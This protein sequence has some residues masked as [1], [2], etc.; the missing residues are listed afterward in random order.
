MTY[1]EW[2][3]LEPS[4]RKQIQDASDTLTPQLRGLEG[5]LVE[6]VDVE[7]R[8]PRRFIV[9]RSSGWLPVNLEC[10]EEGTLGG[11]RAN[12]GYHSVQFIARV[13]DATFYDGTW[14]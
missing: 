4:E 8:E 12:W 11:D 13:R 3:A 7:G 5:C 6:V 14:A 10:H 9:G 1:P 2:V